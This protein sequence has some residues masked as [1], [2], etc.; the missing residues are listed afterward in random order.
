MK[1][2]VAT[3][4]FEILHPGHINFL[5]EAK[6][7]GDR[8]I[9]IVARDKNIGRQKNIVIP[10][11][12]RLEVINSLK[13]VDEAILGDKND[14]FK[15]VEKIKPDIIALGKNQDADE[16]ILTEELKKRN[17]NAKII[18]IENFY[19]ANLNSTT[20]IKEKILKSGKPNK[21]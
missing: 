21:K 10:E 18:R 9:V 14:I 13:V 6:K 8:L 3:G 11:E 4:V 12:Q 15:P 1:T 2:V 20:K 19:N 7:L 16:K 17:L 5:T